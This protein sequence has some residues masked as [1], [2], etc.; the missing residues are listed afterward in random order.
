MDIIVIAAVAP[1]IANVDD[2]TTLRTALGG[3]RMAAGKERAVI[4]SV[5]VA[6]SD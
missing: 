1:H 5:L 4:T 6:G 2:P 3:I